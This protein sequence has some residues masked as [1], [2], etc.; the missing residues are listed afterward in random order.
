MALNPPL[1]GA[2]L[3]PLPRAAA[4]VFVLRRD[5]CV[6]RHCTP[7]Y[8]S[9]CIIFI[10]PRPSVFQNIPHPLARQLEFDFQDGQGLVEKSGTVY[11][12][13]L[14]VV[15][16]PERVEETFSGTSCVLL[17]LAHSF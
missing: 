2:S 8:S 13:S 1:A 3:E 5:G 10:A 12:T 7:S 14:R 15:F 17:C 6:V 4:E 9:L 16:V 11:L